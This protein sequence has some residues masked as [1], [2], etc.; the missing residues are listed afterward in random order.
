M[1]DQLH[2]YLNR[3][4]IFSEEEMNILF[5]LFEYRTFP[6]KEHLLV[7]DELCK[8]QFFIT[9]GLVRSY[10][11]D[12]KG[13]ERIT[14]FAIENWWVTNLDSYKNLSPSAL[15]IQ[16][17][18]K[19]TVLRISKENLELAF[20]S[21]P[22]LERAFR[23]ITENMLVAIQKRYEFYQKKSSKERYQQMIAALPDF[24]QRVPQYMIASYLEI[25]PEYLSSLRKDI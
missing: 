16:A 14:Q 1:K 25:S 8:Y 23:I 12:E 9:E 19:T 10:Y 22:K 11:I 24:S 3:Y 6:K 5:K 21:I 18:E 2:N 7:Q 4:V 17:I 15:F 13:D 20:E